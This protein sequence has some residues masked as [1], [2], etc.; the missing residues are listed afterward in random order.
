MFHLVLFDSDFQRPVRNALSSFSTLLTDPK[1][2]YRTY[3]RTRRFNLV[4]VTTLMPAEAA[5]AFEGGELKEVRDCC[6]VLSDG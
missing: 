4:L 6:R 5:V 1:A 2:F 3:S